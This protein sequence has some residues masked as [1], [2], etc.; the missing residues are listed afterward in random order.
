LKNG[1]ETSRLLPDRFLVFD[2]PATPQMQVTP[3]EVQFKNATDL[4][5][6]FD[7]TLAALCALS[8]R[9]RQAE[10]GTHDAEIDRLLELR[11]AEIDEIVA[12]PV[13]T[14]ADAALKLAAFASIHPDL[15]AD[16]AFTTDARLLRQIAAGL[17][18]LPSA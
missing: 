10:P 9:A 7:Q 3:M 12:A 11:D 18:S 8:A 16:G 4:A 15:F 17:A 2:F 14:V 13:L 1:R 5:D 6:R